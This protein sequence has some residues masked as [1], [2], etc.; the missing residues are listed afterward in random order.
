MAEYLARQRVT[1]IQEP[2]TVQ[3]VYL[4]KEPMTKKVS[5]EVF[6]GVWC[7]PSHQARYD[8]ASHLGEQFTPS[9]FARYTDIYLVLQKAEKNPAL[10]P[11][12]FGVLTLFLVRASRL[13]IYCTLPYSFMNQDQHGF[14]IIRP[15]PNNSS[16]GW[17]STPE[18]FPPECNQYRPQPRGLLHNDSVR[19][20]FRE[21]PQNT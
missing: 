14:H 20:V 16:L 6:Q 2:S 5:G 19:D 12:L 17:W 8:W 9:S 7:W 11:V 10:V 4:E 18:L 15:G 1:T 3:S 21:N 13:Q